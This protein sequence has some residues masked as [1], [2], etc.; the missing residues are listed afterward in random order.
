MAGRLVG[1]LGTAEQW[2]SNESWRVVSISGT[3]D[4]IQIVAIG[5]VPGPAVGLLRWE[6][7]HA[8]YA[9]IAVQVSLVLGQ[10]RKSGGHRPE[11]SP[12]SG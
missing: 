1:R 2:A 11:A 12:S 10:T 3:A 7:D 9:D 5:P 6:V 8:G 4:T